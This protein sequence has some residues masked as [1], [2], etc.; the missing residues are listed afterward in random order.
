ME[1]HQVRARMEEAEQIHYDE[2]LPGLKNKRLALQRISQKVL[3]LLV[4]DCILDQTDYKIELLLPE[5]EI[6]TF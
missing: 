5:F 1:S 6:I 4:R 2:Y 3:T